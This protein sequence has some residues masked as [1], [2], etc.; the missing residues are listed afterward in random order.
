MTY[1]TKH[2]HLFG[3]ITRGS[4]MSKSVAGIAKTIE[5][6]TTNDQNAQYNRG[7][8]LK[9][10]TWHQWCLSSPNHVLDSSVVRFD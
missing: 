3:P 2:K 9:K 1:R 4:V 7:N 8:T 6:L 10:E 5:S